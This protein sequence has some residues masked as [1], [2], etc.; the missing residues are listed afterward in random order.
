MEQEKMEQPIV[1][2][3]DPIETELGAKMNALTALYKKAH[4]ENKGT[5]DLDLYKMPGLMN[6]IKEVE[7]ENISRKENGLTEINVGA[8]PEFQ[9][10]AKEAGGIDA[11]NI[12]RQKEKAAEEMTAK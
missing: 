9:T 8:M 3:K 4:A 5:T 2:E 1:V 11:T 10:L 12:A 6:E 7:K